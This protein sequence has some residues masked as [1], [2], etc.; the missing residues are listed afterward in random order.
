[1]KIGRREFLAGGL[2]GLAACTYARPDGQEFIGGIGSSDEPRT[3]AEPDNILSIGA[4]GTIVLEAIEEGYQAVR[5][6]GQDSTLIIDDGAGLR[7]D[8]V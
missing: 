7:F 5:W 8:T 1:M 6:E 3:V 4:G 2:A